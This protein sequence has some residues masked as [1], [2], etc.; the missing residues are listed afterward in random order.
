MEKKIS[1]SFGIMVIAFLLIFY[2]LI[3]GY[4]TARLNDYRAF[5]MTINR[6]I[7]ERN[8]NDRML[9]MQL[10]MEQRTNIDLKNTL[11]DTRNAL[12]VLSKKL[13]QPA[14]PMAPASAPAPAA[15]K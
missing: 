5:R 2:I 4:N 11:A 10:A 13:A 14:M 15:A 3:K 6:I 8:A 12:D 1:L 7:N 9:Y